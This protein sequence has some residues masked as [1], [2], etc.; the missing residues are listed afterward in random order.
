MALVNVL[1]LL[2]WYRPR[3]TSFWRATDVPWS[4]LLTYSS[5]YSS[6]LTL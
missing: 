2:I 1:K 4:N 5:S 3:R 6:W